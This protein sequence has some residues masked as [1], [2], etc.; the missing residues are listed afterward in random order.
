M[1][2]GIPRLYR[3]LVGCC[4][5]TGLPM[6]PD[7]PKLWATAGKPLAPPGEGPKKGGGV[8]ERVISLGPRACQCE[9]WAHCQ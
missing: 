7:P 3:L 4:W 8:G 5:A 6:Y 2:C 1:P 9:V